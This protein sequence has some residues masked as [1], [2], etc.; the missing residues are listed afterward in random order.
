[1]KKVEEGNEGKERENESVSARECE[2]VCVACA[3][4]SM[5]WWPQERAVFTDCVPSRSPHFSYINTATCL[6]RARLPDPPSLPSDLSLLLIYQRNQQFHLR[7]SPSVVN[8][9]SIDQ[10]HPT[11]DLSAQNNLP[12]PANL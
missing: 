2:S 8:I 7:N 1:M 4:G 12:T 9:D 10:T 6:D 3:W 11:F 5:V